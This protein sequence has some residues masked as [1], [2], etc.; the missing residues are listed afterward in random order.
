MF[1]GAEPF[2]EITALLYKLI[3]TDRRRYRELRVEIADWVWGIRQKACK[4]SLIRHDDMDGRALSSR[5]RMCSI[6][7]VAVDNG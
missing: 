2:D 5:V 4:L 3:Q 7:W 6:Q 1:L